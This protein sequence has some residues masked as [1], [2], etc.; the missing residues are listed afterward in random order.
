MLGEIQIVYLSIFP[1]LRTVLWKFVGGQFA[2]LFWPH[3]ADFP[4]LM[5]HVNVYTDHVC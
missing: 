5:S 3:L 4:L 1:Q 2:A